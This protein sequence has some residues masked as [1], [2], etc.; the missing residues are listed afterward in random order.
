MAK[1]WAL[2]VTICFLVI[3]LTNSCVGEIHRAKQLKKSFGS[4]LA[5]GGSFQEKSAQAGGHSSE[6]WMYST[7]SAI[8]VGLSGIFPLV[9]I[10]IE[11]GKALR[12]GGKCHVCVC[13]YVLESLRERESY[14]VHT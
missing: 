6:T 5:E 2:C 12:K 10:P 11:A 14:V 4:R 3:C 8:L 9:V 13:V 1:H 7:I